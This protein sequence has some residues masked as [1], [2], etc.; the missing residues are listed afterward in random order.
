MQ[1]ISYIYILASGFK[2][3]YIGVTSNLDIRIRQHKNET[4]PDSFTARNNMKDLV[5]FERF[6]DINSAIAREKQLK[7]WSRI[8]K[9]RLIVAENPTWRD[10][11][12]HPNRS[13]PTNLPLLL[14]CVYSNPH[15]NVISTEG[16]AF[17][18]A[19]ERSLYFV[20]GRCRCY[21]RGR[22]LFFDPAT[23]TSSRPKTAHL[24]P[25]LKTSS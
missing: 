8:K 4:D 2:H 15:P 6:A 23:Q 11:S 12:I 16:G 24:P 3:L 13:P 14:P 20:F 10:L 22:C 17:A 21:C 25:R 19:V 9:I 18:A 7:R 1:E 5:Y